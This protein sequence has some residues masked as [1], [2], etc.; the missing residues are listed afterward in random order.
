MFCAFKNTR[1]SFLFWKFSFSRASFGS[2]SFYSRAEFVVKSGSFSARVRQVRKPS[3]FSEFLQ[4]R[5]GVRGIREGRLALFSFLG[6]T[7]NTGDKFELKLNKV[8]STQHCVL[9]KYENMFFLTFCVF[10]SPLR[11]PFVLSACVFDRR[12]IFSFLSSSV[13][14]YFN[15]KQTIH[16][17]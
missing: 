16:T 4:S 2:F 11:L 12:N 3:M 1:V 6:R 13:T 7:I 15:L 8:V 17:Q 14:D 9:W 5:R 10:A